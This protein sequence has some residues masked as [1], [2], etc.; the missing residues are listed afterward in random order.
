MEIFFDIFLKPWHKALFPLV[1]IN[2]EKKQL[3]KNGKSKDLINGY[4]AIETKKNAFIL[5]E[6]LSSSARVLD[7]ETNPS[8]LQDQE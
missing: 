7:Y 8:F 3:L 5:M 6:T 4:E 1:L 2:L